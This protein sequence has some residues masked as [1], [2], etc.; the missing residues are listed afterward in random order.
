MENKAFANEYSYLKEG[1][2]I[3][4][5]TWFDKTGKKYSGNELSGKQTL[6]ILFTEDCRHCRNNFAYLEQNLFQK[7]KTNMNILAFGR[8]C[9]DSCIEMY[10]KKYPVSIKLFADPGNLIYSKFAEKVV[11][12]L[13]LFNQ[14][15][16]LT[17]S[18][19]GF[20]PDMIDKM[21]EILI[22]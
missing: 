19:R 2:P 13:Y 22:N 10:M 18:I 11:P 8:G 5:L 15:G 21:V 4:D 6:V 14:E 1:D 7:V 3:P 17:L 20:R 12:R 9:D 16:K